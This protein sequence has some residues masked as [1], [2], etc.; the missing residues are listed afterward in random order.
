MRVLQLGK[1]YPPSRGGIETHVHTLAHA[2]VEL[3]AEVEALVVNHA[4]LEGDVVWRAAARTRTREEQDA[5]VRVLRAGRVANLARLDLCPR[6]PLL[7]SRLAAR[8]DVVH[9]HV[10][11]PTMGLALAGLP[12][13]AAPLVITHHSD[14]LR[15]RLLRHALRPLDELLYARAARLLATSPPYA[16]SSPQLARRRAKVSVLPLGIDLTPFRAPSPAALEEA[17]RLR[18]RYPGP[19]WLMVGRLVYYKGHRVAL[20][21]LRALPGTLLVVGTGPLAGALWDEARALGVEERT[22]F[23]GEVEAAVLEGAYQAATALLF[24][25]TERTEAF[26]LAQVEAMAAGRP[27][28]NAALAGSGVPWV[29]PHEEAGLSAP[30]GDDAALAAGARRLLEEEGLAARLGAGG[31]ARAEALFS[32]EQMARAALELYREVAP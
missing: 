13:L 10:P 1:Y 6:L 16:E 7:I 14:V 21:A 3:G 12:R 22:A 27:V 30:P 28:L 5:G 17:A 29:C 24:P 15:Q 32:R 20:R 2:L 25:G 4:N 9:L 11:N 8:A 18:E 31:R 19:L 23:L 26:G